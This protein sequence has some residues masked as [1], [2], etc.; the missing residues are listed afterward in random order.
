MV[1]RL[2]VAV[3][4]GVVA[5]GEAVAEDGAVAGVNGA[6][7]SSLQAITVSN[8]RRAVKNRMHRLPNLFIA[9]P[10][11]LRSIVGRRW[12]IELTS[13]ISSWLP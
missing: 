11:Y 12:R 10:P 7:S 8:I 9:N 2:G 1:I 13:G 3:G 4:F 6:E 5:S